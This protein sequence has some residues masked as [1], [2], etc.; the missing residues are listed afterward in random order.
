MA[1]VLTVVL[2]RRRQ[3]NKLAKPKPDATDTEA[4]SAAPKGTIPQRR[5]PARAVSMF[6][7]AH[8]RCI[9][10]QSKDV[11][12]SRMHPHKF[13]GIN[14]TDYFRCKACG[15]HFAIVSYTTIVLAGGGIAL[16]LLLLVASVVWRCRLNAAAPNQN[17]THS[18]IRRYSLPRMS[19]L[20]RP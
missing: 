6:R 3:I 11:R 9:H 20:K 17:A 8:P 1:V 18:S 2:Y 14:F 12:P 10:C 13:A 16:S 7:R 19:C 5:K 4:P 15:R